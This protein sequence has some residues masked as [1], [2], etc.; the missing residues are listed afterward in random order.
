MC[1]QVCESIISFF[2]IWRSTSL[3]IRWLVPL[4]AYSPHLFDSFFFQFLFVL[5]HLCFFL[6]FYSWFGFIS[7][8]LYSGRQKMHTIWKTDGKVCS[9]SIYKMRWVRTKAMNVIIEVNSANHCSFYSREYWAT[10]QRYLLEHLTKKHSFV[11]VSMVLSL[12]SFVKKVEGRKRRSMWKI[13]KKATYR[14]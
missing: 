3:V 6:A 9:I 10:K 8:D 7:R 4:S 11:F 2:R 1:I 14:K 13:W 12:V 5:A